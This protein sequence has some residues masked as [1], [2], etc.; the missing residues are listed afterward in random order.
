MA[1]PTL[2]PVLSPDGMRLDWLDCCARWDAG[3]NARAGPF[4]G[5]YATGLARLLCTMGC[6]EKTLETVLSPDGMRLDW[7]DCCARWDA[8]KKRSG[9]SFHRMVCDWTGSIVV[10]DGMPGKNA[11]AGPFTGWYATGR[12]IVV[13][14]GMPGKNARAGPFTGWYATGLARLLCTMG[15]REKTLGPV[16]SPDGMRLDWLDCCARWDAGKKRSRRSFH[17]MVCDWTGSIVVHD[18]MPEKTEGQ[19]D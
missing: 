6:R 19:F 1:V 18:G 14:D 17:R 11:R 12:S 4:T 7:L 2:G 9:R 16:L 8:G 13:H 15:C 5:W 3:K 10:H